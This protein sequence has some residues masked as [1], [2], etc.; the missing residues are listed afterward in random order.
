[1]VGNWCALAIPHE[2]RRMPPC[3]ILLRTVNVFALFCA[4][5]L[6]PASDEGDVDATEFEK[7]LV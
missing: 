1:M 6:G 4:G 7:R 3:V 5:N 2:H